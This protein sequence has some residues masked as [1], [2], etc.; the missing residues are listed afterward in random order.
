[1]FFSTSSQTLAAANTG[2][3]ITFN[4]T[5]LGNDVSI[6][7]DSEITTGINGVYNFQFS[8]QLTSTNASAKNVY[9]WLNR[10]GSDITYST[11]AYTISGSGTEMAII[12][13]FS[14][15]MQEDSYIEIHWAADDTN[16]TL[17]SSGA[18]SPHPGMAS[19]V[20]SVLLASALPPT[21][22]TLP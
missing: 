16:V 21:L 6:A 11:H 9:I 20:V 12:W 19:A 17:T 18:S 10:N 4:Q 22:P 13:D 14:I 15:D 3:A 2:Y 7:N 5:Y 1:M 8:G